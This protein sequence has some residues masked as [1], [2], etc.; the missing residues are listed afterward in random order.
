MTRRIRSPQEARTW[1]ELRDLFAFDAWRY[2]RPFVTVQTADYTTTRASSPVGPPG[3]EIVIADATGT[4]VQTITLAT[5]PVDQQRVTVKRKRTGP[6]TVAT[7][8]SETIDGA[9]SV[10]VGTQYDAPLMLYTED[11]GEWI[12]I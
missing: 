7:E 3:W 11:G 5:N 1:E 8:G 4:S 6:V 10:T 9:A 12:L 2:I